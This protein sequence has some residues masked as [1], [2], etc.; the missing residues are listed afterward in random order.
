MSRLITMATWS[1]PKNRHKGN[2]GI[3]QEW[4]LTED[5]AAP[6]PTLPDPQ[7]PFIMWFF[8]PGAVCAHSRA[9][10]HSLLCASP[11]SHNDNMTI[12]QYTYIYIYNCIYIPYICDKDGAL[13]NNN[14]RHKPLQESFRPWSL[15]VFAV[16]LRVRSFKSC[17]A[18]VS[19]PLCYLWPHLADPSWDP[20]T[21]CATGGFECINKIERNKLR[22]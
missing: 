11:I 15:H 22:A 21:S 19:T 18:E 9:P 13:F 7:G 10:D 20:A 2:T 12:W 1:K 5:L 6:L 8:C 17:A 3:K 16:M 4:R 14:I